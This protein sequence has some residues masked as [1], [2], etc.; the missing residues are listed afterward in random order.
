MDAAGAGLH[1]MVFHRSSVGSMLRCLPC[2]FAVYSCKS[3]GAVPR[4][5]GPAVAMR[6]ISLMISGTETVEVVELII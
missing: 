2:F 5:L 4:Q 1:P 6:Q 3:M